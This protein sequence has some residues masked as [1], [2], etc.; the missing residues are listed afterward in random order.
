M[1]VR[2]DRIVRTV[3]ANN[4]ARRRGRSRPHQNSPSKTQTNGANNVESRLVARHR[5]STGTENKNGTEIIEE[6]IS[7]RNTLIYLDLPY[8]EKGSSLYLNS[9][10][11]DDHTDLATLLNSHCDKCWVLTYDNKRQ[12]KKLY[13]ERRI[14]NF[15]IN[16]SAHHVCSGK[17]I[18]ILA[19][20][21]SL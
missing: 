15:S 1:N 18:V 13:G 2:S 6:Y 11:V 14:A 21:V 3:Y 20:S 4:P 7:K 9:F 12:I 5:W 8:F 16:Y 17:E 19:D 10:K